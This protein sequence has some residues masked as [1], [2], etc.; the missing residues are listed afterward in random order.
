MKQMLP[1]IITDNN[2]FFTIVNG[3]NAL[4]GEGI[5]DALAQDFFDLGVDVI[6]GGNHSLQDFS[7]RQD[8]L[9]NPHCLRPAN[10]PL[11]GGRGAIM[12]EKQDLHIFTA[13]ILGR[14]DMRY[15][16]SPFTCIDTLLS[17][18]KCD[19]SII[20]F[21]AESAEEKEAFGF[22]VDGRVSAVFGTHT[23]VQTA[24]EKIL[25]QGTAYITDVGMV[26]AVNSI[27]GSYVPY[28][29]EKVQRMFSNLPRWQNR[30][31]AVFSA[32]AVTIDV[33]TK[34]TIALKRIQEQC[35]V[36]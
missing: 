17:N 22:Y 23:H 28:S 4:D 19:I 10:I 1:K 25:P 2:I 27:I 9:A 6:T 11:V 35:T 12:I 16:D 18:E 30:G 24:D 26:G 32:L 29:T 34:K 3:E 21:H 5:D 14:E 13:N 36:K 31:Q 7:L 33:D 8:F 20:D 15:V